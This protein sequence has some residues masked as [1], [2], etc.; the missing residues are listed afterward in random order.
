MSIH[1]QSLQV[2]ATG[3]CKVDGPDIIND[4]FEQIN[5]SFETH[6][7][8]DLS[9]LPVMVWKQY[10]T[11]VKNM[12]TVCIYIY[13]YIYIIYIYINNYLYVLYNYIYLYY[14]IF[15]LVYICLYIYIYIYLFIYIYI[16]IDYIYIY[17]YKK[18]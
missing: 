15:I 14:V 8:L 7:R 2:L 17:I 13:I 11:Y 12:G 1:Y 16:Y 5:M 18:N 10:F 3:I 6:N 4:I 9:K